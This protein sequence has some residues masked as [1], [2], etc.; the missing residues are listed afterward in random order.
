MPSSTIQHI[1]VSLKRI[2]AGIR[3]LFE[4]VDLRKETY[5]EHNAVL[6]PD[7]TLYE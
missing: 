3:D 5:V 6:G 4:K 7:G 1:A 2:K